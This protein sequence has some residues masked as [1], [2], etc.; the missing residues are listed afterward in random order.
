MLL[1]YI[2]LAL[3]VAFGLAF[4]FDL[5]TPVFNHAVHFFEFNFGCA[6][7]IAIVIFCTSRYRSFI[8][9]L[10]SLPWIVW[11]GDISYSIYAVH[12]WTLRPFMRPSVDLTF[13]TGTD[14]VFRIAFAIMF[15]IIVA[16][17]TYRIIEVPCRRYLRAKLMRP[18]QLEFAPPKMA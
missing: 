17:A 15:T 1:L 5:G 6:V 11:L 3:A 16:S 10:L 2:A 14:A 12:T 13:A 4:A 7:P 8:A 9:A 18:R